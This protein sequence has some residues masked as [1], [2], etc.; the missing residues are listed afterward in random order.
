[1]DFGFPQFGN[2]YSGAQLRNFVTR[3]SNALNYV[4][5]K[6][7]IFYHKNGL[8]GVVLGTAGVAGT[9]ATG[10]YTFFITP[11]TGA[12]SFAGTVTAGAGAIGGWTIGAT[13]LTSGSGANTV[14]LDSGGTNPAF[15]AGSATPATAPALPWVSIWLARLKMLPWHLLRPLALKKSVR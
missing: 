11:A 8:A 7:P 5:G 4:N 12:A 15:Y 1:M 2:E 13:S 6:D 14:G 10:A 9:D 3:V